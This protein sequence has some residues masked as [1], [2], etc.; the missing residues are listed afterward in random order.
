MTTK[1]AS[2]KAYGELRESGALSR[3]QMIVLATVAEG[4]PMTRSEIA[5]KSGLR[6][7]AVCGRANALTGAGLLR[8]AF[9]APCPITGKTAEH[10]EATT[11]GRLSLAANTRSGCEV[12]A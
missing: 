6:L 9:K 3:Q 8:V 7:C 4:S 2:R 1:S 12:E 5:A 11:V 10:L